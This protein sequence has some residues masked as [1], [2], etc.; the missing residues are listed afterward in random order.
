MKEEE[1]EKGGS[2]RRTTKSPP[3]SLNYMSVFPPRARLLS[4]PAP[5]EGRLTSKLTVESIPVVTLIRTDTTLDHSQKAE[6][7]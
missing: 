7:V 6:K 2:R 3:P 1:G 4:V 5:P